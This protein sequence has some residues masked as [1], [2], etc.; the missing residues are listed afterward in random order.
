VRC[1]PFDD[2]GAVAACICRDDGAGQVRDTGCMPCRSHRRSHCLELRRWSPPSC[3]EQ[4]DIT[5]ASFGPRTPKSRRRSRCGC[6]SK[7]RSLRPHRGLPRSGHRHEPGLVV[8]T[9]RAVAGCIRDDAPRRGANP[10]PGLV[11]S[12]AG[13]DLRWLAPGTSSDP[14]SL[15]PKRKVPTVEPEGSTTLGDSIRS[16]GRPADCEQSG[17][18]VP[19]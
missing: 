4:V 16:R 11:S 13:V 18:T 5:P 19:R 9:A 1:T 17:S 10:T 2:L 8:S 15:P 12:R 6:F 3:A 7:D 14:P